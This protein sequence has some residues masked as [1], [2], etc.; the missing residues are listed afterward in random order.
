MVALVRAFDWG[1]TP[2]G[3]MTRWPQSLRT[4]AS[5]CLESRQ[6]M[7]LWWGPELT[8][9]YNDACRDLIGEEDPPTLGR[10][11]RQV[12]REIWHVIGPVVEDVVARG[13][14]AAL[15]DVP[16][17]L[18]RCGRLEECY[19]SFSCTPVEDESGAIA[20]V[21]TPVIETTQRVVAARR[22]RTLRDLAA[23]GAGETLEEVARAP[24]EAL[25]GDPADVSFALL[26]LVDAPGTQARL[27]CA[28]G[29][30]SGTP[31]TPA[32]VD[33]TAAGDGWPLARVAS[34][35]RA[36]I[37]PDL[38]ARFG[39][40]PGG[41]WP[42]ASES[43][44]V[45]PVGAAAQGHAAGVLVA[46]ISPV[47]ALD[48]DY[49][50]FLDLA[51]GY[52]A[53]A[54]AGVRGYMGPEAQRLLM[55]EQEARAEAERA[56]RM[57]DQFLAIVSHEL[58]TPL[59]AMLAWIRILR[60]GKLDAD[61]A[62]RALETVERNARAQ[63]KLVEDILDVSRIVSGKL[64]LELRAVD[65]V[66]VVEAALEAVRP[67]A[68]AKGVRI[69]LDVD[70]SI[71][72]VAGDAARLQQVVWN[73]VSNA[74][75]YTPGGG[76][77]EVRLRRVNSHVEV[78][79]RDTGQ[80]IAAEFLPFVFEPFRQG[81]GMTTR[82]H[83]G[84]GLGL[85]LVR[86]LVELH[87]GK[88]EAASAGEG[89]GATFTVTLPLMSGG[90]VATHG[91]LADP[92]ARQ[93]SF[94]ELGGV[95]VLVIDDDP[96]A[97]EVLTTVLEYCGARVTAASSVADALQALEDGAPD[98]L[99]SDIAMPGADGYELIRRVRESGV[100][101]IRRVPAVALTAHAGEED[102]WRALRAGF[103]THVAKPVEPG[104]LA[105]VVANL[106]RWR[107]H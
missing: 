101:D 58:R 29:L 14:A 11:G 99:V 75:K 65:M 53:A 41:P 67:A 73:L 46:G 107:S 103:Q 52:V 54:L 49:R 36:E 95:H 28:A 31:A 42:A 60:S 104:E 105:T 94:P 4:A 20:G 85:A 5:I 12:W 19:F 44:L 25:A 50:A 9:L 17:V 7:V 16:L 81:E 92:A 13:E 91:H 56:N 63:A 26:Y 90:L 55:R 74:I 70:P 2:L 34:T 23:G 18:A 97:R 32:V 27:V 43:A 93:V 68:D 3:P 39:V 57:K 72:R 61:K 100:E 106:A 33:L 88:I 84:L 48:D 21:C 15:D 59:S 6:P 66:P 82:S 8:T 64:R 47:R 79:M 86:N 24:I 45:L 98:V 22:L 83:G 76:E 77:V 10:P 30:A 51:A 1:A 62:K 87:G 35:G 80:G 40:L 69:Q 89:R 78:V 96:D 38:I 71:A 102:R 37:V